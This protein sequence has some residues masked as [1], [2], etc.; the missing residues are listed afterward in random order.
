MIT[1]DPVLRKRLDEAGQ[2][3]RDQELKII[4]LEKEVELLK[5]G[6]NSPKADFMTNENFSADDKSKGSE[7]SEKLTPPKAGCREETGRKSKDTKYQS[8]AADSKQIHSTTL[9]Q[10]PG[11]GEARPSDRSAYSIP[12]PNRRA[13]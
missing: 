7:L 11:S 9:N 10:L 8:T 1:D 12:Q 3:A 2:R 4:I 13:K 5:A 6:K